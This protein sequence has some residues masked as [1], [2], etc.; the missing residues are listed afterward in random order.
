MPRLRPRSETRKNILAL[1]QLSARN[2]NISNLTGLEHATNLITLNL[3]AENIEAQKRWINSNS[4]SDL[5]PLAGLINLTTLRLGENSI[6]DLAPLAGLIG[7]RDLRL[8]NNSIADISPV[9]EL[10]NLSILAVENNSITDISALAGLTNLTWLALN[11]NNISDISPLIENAG[12]GSRDE[13]HLDGNPLSYASIYTHIPALQARG[14]EVFFTNRTPQ[15]IR[16][17]SGHNQQGLPGA[18]LEKPFVVEVRDERGVA[19]EGV[20]V[21]FTVTTGNGKLSIANTTTDENGRAQ[22][23]LTLGPNPS[24]N[25]VTVSVTGIQEAQTVSAFAE[26]ARIPED[27]NRDDVVNIL[28][29]VLVASVLGETG[30][31]LM[32]DVN[33]DGIVNILDLVLVAGALGNTAAAPSAWDRDLERDFHGNSIAF[34]IHSLDPS[35]STRLITPT[36]A[37]VNKW[38]INARALEGLDEMMKRGI[39]TL[40]KLLVALTPSETALLPNYPNPFNPETWIP[41]QLEEGTEVTL[42]IYD[43]NGIMVRRLGLGHQLAGYHAERGRAAYWDGRNDVGEGVASGVYFYHLSTGDYSATRKMLIIK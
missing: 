36:T 42:T 30:Q 33:G 8:F 39:V 40:E 32:A 4:V 34:A 19:F 22:S 21:T 2:A 20:P 14:V 17:M 29:L 12:L 5:S 23:R 31:D 15:R 13:I 27:V 26:S 11:Y 38:L 24:T 3:E 9:S 1:T 16:I 18:V 43:A 37:S 41:Y 7:L 28:D 10:T 35:L 6:S 25:T